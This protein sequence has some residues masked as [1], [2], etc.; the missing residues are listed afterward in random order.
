MIITG[1]WTAEIS[2]LLRKLRPDQR[3]TTTSTQSIEAM[4][5]PYGLSGH[6]FKH[7]AGLVLLQ[8][9][10][11]QKIRPTSMSILMKH[12]LPPGQLPVAPTT[13]R[14]LQDPAGKAELFESGLAT[15][16]L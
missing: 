2:D 5:K 10:K 14:Y 16:L 13:L 15:G 1:S 4:L 8:G 7:G 11:A 3:V 9:V 6:S 12:K